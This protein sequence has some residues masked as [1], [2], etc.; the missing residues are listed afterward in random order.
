MDLGGFIR[1]SLA[2][3]EQPT[4][5]ELVLN[6]NTARSLGVSL[7][8]AILAPANEAIGVRY[9][10]IDGVPALPVIPGYVDRK[11]TPFGDCIPRRR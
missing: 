9:M 6:L 10:N 5:F 11:L 4:K 8:P 7:S 3:I 1:A 2:W